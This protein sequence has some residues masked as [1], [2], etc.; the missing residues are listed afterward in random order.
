LAIRTTNQGTLLKWN[1]TLYTKSL[2][3][4][5]R[6]TMFLK[7]DDMYLTQ[8]IIS[9]IIM[10]FRFS[11]WLQYLNSKVNYRG[12]VEYWDWRKSP[13][14]INWDV[15]TPEKIGDKK[16]LHSNLLSCCKNRVVCFELHK[17]VK[18]FVLYWTHQVSCS[19]RTTVICLLHID[20]LT[21]STG[22]RAGRS[23]F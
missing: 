17:A 3:L 8:D 18:L 23:G 11:F 5:E 15:K 2:C 19:V 12:Q 20:S 10:E 14:E 16:I 13:S 22:L 6:L 7:Y 9:K 4:T 21:N 1:Y